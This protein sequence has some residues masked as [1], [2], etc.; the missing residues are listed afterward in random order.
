M[1]SEKKRIVLN[2]GTLKRG[3]Q[4]QG[5]TGNKPH[6]PPSGQGTNTSNQAKGSQKK[7]K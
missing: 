4:G 2:E 7:G 5:A 6:I 1:S 3:N